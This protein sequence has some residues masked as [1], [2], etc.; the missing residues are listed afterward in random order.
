[1]A[2]GCAFPDYTTTGDATAADSKAADSS[3]ESTPDGTGDADASID[4]SPD[5]D[6]A[7]T[8]A[9]DADACDADGCSCDADCG[10]PDLIFTAVSVA[11]GAAPALMGTIPGKKARKIHI[12]KVGIC[13]DSD[14]ASGPN[15]FLASDSGAM[16]FSWSCG[17]TAVPS[18]F[19]LTPTPPSGTGPAAGRGWTYK[20]VDQTAALSTSVSV[21]WDYHNDWD[22]LFCNAPDE[23]GNAYADPAATVRVWVRYRYE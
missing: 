1:M 14:A 22:G 21:T 5:G 10:T 7:V 6:A 11:S 15:R 23:L 13:G 16:S 17:Q 9:S 18:T 2:V 4:G 20:A 12:L 8:D 19:T 3:F